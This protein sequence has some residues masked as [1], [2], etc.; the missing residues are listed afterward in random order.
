VS[1]QVF[2]VEKVL[3]GRDLGPAPDCGA[4]LPA[5]PTARSLSGSAAPIARYLHLPDP[6]SAE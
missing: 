6:S 3:R 1:S 4:F 5:I 2:G